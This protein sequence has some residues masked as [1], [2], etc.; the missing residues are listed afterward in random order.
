VG[1]SYFIVYVIILSI[2]ETNK[3]VFGST[4]LMIKT[5]SKIEIF[6]LSRDVYFRFDVAKSRDEIT[7]TST[8]A[9]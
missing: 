8:P 5:L 9:P 3:I 2:S 6:V 1:R 4:I 7:L